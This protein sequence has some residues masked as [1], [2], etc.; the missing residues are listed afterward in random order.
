MLALRA[1]PGQVGLPAALSTLAFLLIGL[2]A[3]AWTDRMRKRPLMI[4]ADLA[5]AVVFGSVP[6]AWLLRVLKIYQLYG[7]VLVTGVCTVFFDVAAQSHLPHLVGH[8]RLGRA[9]ARLVT[10]GAVTEIG[11]RGVGGLLVTLVSAPA[12]IGLDAATYLGSAVFLLRVRRPEPRPRH[13]GTTALRR[14]IGEGVR[15]VF[16][17]AVLRPIA[18]AGTCTNL[19]IQLCQTMLP[20]VFVRLGLPGG[21]IGVFFAVG[22]AGTLLGS[23]S[24]RRLARRLGSGRVLWLVGLAIAPTGICV[25]LVDRGPALWLAATAWLLITFKVGVDNVIK[26]SFRQAVTP[27][28]L[29]GRMNATMRFVLTGA[30][31][32]GGA[33]AGLLGQFVGV[34]AALWAGAVLFALVW[35][36]TFFSPLRTAQALP[37]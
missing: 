12:A 9:N 34:R 30:L 16:G 22:G 4:A 19:A 1:S 18:L 5:R 29:L 7:V 6:L 10:L 35:V 26:V 24:A 17:H 36:P 14:D 13:A 25:A 31:A 21:A 20:V 33:L 8:D 15:Y 2:P 32:V 23:L 28:R 27:D 3:G 11:G 37:S